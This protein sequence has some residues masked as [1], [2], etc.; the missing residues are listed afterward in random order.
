MDVKQATEN[1]AEKETLLALLLEEAGIELPRVQSITQREKADSYPLSFAQ[2]RLWFLAQLE[3]DSNQYNVPLTLHLD[4]KLSV[5]VLEKSLA[6]ILRRHEALRTC[7][8]VIDD[9]PMQVISAAQALPLP[10]TDL[11]QLVD[12]ASAAERIAQEEAQ[13]RFDLAAGPLFRARLLRLGAEEHVLLLT[14]HHIVSD[15]WSTG[16]LVQ[17]LSA[18]YTAYAQR[19]PSPLAELAIQYADYAVWQRGWLQGA[20]LDEQLQY[21]REQLEGAPAVLELPTDHSRPAVQSFRGARQS[22]RLDHGVSEQLQELSRREGVTLFMSLLAA[23]QVLLARYSG[24]E[25]IVVGSPIAGRTRG[26]TEGLIGFFVNTLVLRGDLSGDPSF[27]E[28]LQRVKEV[29]LGAYG[30]QEVPFEKLVEEL[31]P[32]R[33]LSHNPLFQVMFV[34]QNTPREEL[35]LPGL[36][37]TPV[38]VNDES[39]TKFDLTL[40]ALQQGAGL[41]VDLEYNRDLFEAATVQRML[42]HFETLLAGI[43]AAPQQRLSELPFLTPAEQQRLLVEWNDTSRPLPENKCIHQLFEKQV[44]LT[45]E[46]VAVSDEKKQLSYA[47]LNA[48]A[49][50]LAHYLGEQGVRA[51]VLVGICMERS[52]ELVVSLLAVLKAGGAYV[53]LD[54]TYPEQRLSYMLQ[55]AGVRVLLSERKWRERVAVR[56]GVQVLCREDWSAELASR[57]AANPAV[58]LSATNLAYVIYTSGST[59]K[60]KGVAIE[61]HSTTTF[62]SWAKE[63]FS[64]AE[65]AGVLFSTSICFDLSVFEMFTPLSC[66]GKVIVAGNAL[67]LPS[68]AEAPEVTLIN[69]VPSA[70]AELLR[71]GGIPDSVRTVNLAGEPLQ[72]TLV[73]QIYESSCVERV[74]NLYGP[75]EDTTYSTYTLVKRGLEGAPTIGRPIANTEVYIL[76]KELRPVPVGVSGELY[77]AGEGL[78][79][80]YLHRPELTAERFVPHPYSTRPGARAYR[81]GDAARYLANGEIEY[82]G[83]LDHQVKLRGYRIELGEVESALNAQAGVSE[84][85]V[86]VREDE[87]GEKRLVGYVVAEAGA[88]VSSSE[89][90]RGL[91]ERLPE[92][93]VP[94]ALVLLERL[95]LTA[96]GKV[97]RRELPAPDGRRP[98]LAAAYV[99]PRTVVEEVLVEIWREVL[100]VEQVGIHDNFFELGGHSLLATQVV[101]RVRQVLQREMGLRSLFERPTVAGL[102]EQLEEKSEGSSAPPPVLAVGREQSLPLSFAQQRLWLI[103]QLEQGTAAYNIPAALR[104]R[105]QLQVPVLEA[106][107]TEVVRRHEALRT[108]FPLIDGEPVQL[109]SAA[110]ALPLPLTD[111]SQQAEAANLVETIAQE[112]AQQRFD[113]A[114]GPLFRARL[115]RLGAEEHVL[116]LTMHHIV[117]DGWSIGVLV[118]ELSALYTAYAQRQSS[119]LAELAIQYAD[120]AVWQR[121]WL[122]GAVLDEQ[123]QYWREQLEG[124]PAVLE[125]PTDHSR[126]AVQ[127]FRGARHSLRLDHGVSDQLKELSRREGVTLFM[128]LLAA[129]QVLLARYSGQEEIVVGS[130][131]AGRTRSETEGLIGFFVNTLVLRGD[132][133]GDPSFAELLQ[134][135]KE[136]CLGAYGHQ[137]VPFEKLVEELQ[138]ERS[139]SHNPL[140]QVMFVLQNTPREELRLPDLELTPVAVNNESTKFD[141]TLIASERGAELQVDLEYNRDLFEAATV[142]RMLEQFE[143]VLESVALNPLERLSAIRMLGAE[144]QRQLI[145]E[146]NDTE[147]VCGAAVSVHEAF[148]AQ[149]ARSPEA[150]AVVWGTERITYAELNERANQLG[151]YLQRAGVGPEVRVG[152]WLERSIEMVVGVLGV[153]K[154][155]GAYV[156][157]DPQHPAERV[158]FMAR[159]A[160]LKVVLQGES[161]RR[162]PPEIKAK[163]ISLAAERET[164]ARERVTNV[165][166]KAAPENLAYVIYTSGSMGQPKGVLI[167]HRSALNLSGALQQR[168]YQ[169]HEERPMRVSMNAPLTFDS[170][171]KQWLT[172]LFGCTLYPVPEAVR[173]D[174]EALLAFVAAHELQVLDCTPSQL[175]TLIEEWAKP[176]HYCPAVLLVGGE[177]IERGLWRQLRELER[178]D[179][180]NLY[181]PTECT[182][183]A[184]ISR[185]RTSGEKPNIGRP[186]ANTQVYLL[187]RQGTLVP[188]GAVGE[189]HIGGVGVGRGYLERAD[190][191]AARFIPNPFREAVGERLYRTG[192][193]ARYGANG[194]L[195]FLGRVDQQVKVRGFRIELGEVEAELNRHPAIRDTVVSVRANAAGLTRLVAY[196]ILLAG[197]GVRRSELR[198]HLKKRL[199]DYMIPSTFMFLDA[200]PLTRNGKVDREALPL[201]AEGDL[202]SVFVAPRTP[203]EKVLVGVWEEVLKVDRVGVHDSFFELGGHSLLATQVISRLRQILQVELSLRSLFEMPRVADLAEHL[204]REEAIPGQIS[205]TAALH[206]KIS[207]M[208]AAEVQALLQ[209]KKRLEANSSWM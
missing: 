66:G 106:A 194:C 78:A 141:L 84:A 167:E 57:S 32:E 151:H 148:E 143:R 197:Q 181:G 67:D 60:P 85:V 135:V 15:G 102:A 126:P 160:G 39:T 185:T 82:Q 119:P 80:G 122:Q 150:T 189:L 63:V 54:P 174:S 173:G 86:V 131:I 163:V 204:I 52:V 1:N 90:R 136:V 101:S 51:D 83:R 120:Y 33:S 133:S 123:L 178:V 47:E 16:V 44:R 196:V 166:S 81:T 70:M 22:L 177:A 71:I 207:K 73:Q 206:L 34:L 113:L 3:L 179:S 45:P 46:A 175:T 202:E 118:K 130:P 53:P 7:F 162:L 95:P 140:F 29:C 61:H 36:E 107:L 149:V 129:W 97:N 124:A 198:A 43:V 18:L 125:L 183:D 28:L 68:L 112:E 147:V 138:P 161:E 98:E 153:L 111:L 116:L 27:A 41:Q 49:N 154:A 19:Q 10:L 50:Q 26:E 25:E 171:V 79:R 9:E 58:E 192:D 89:L 200:L 96:N 114:A 12:G 157:L 99:G 134:R 155:G 2:Q 17:E 94:A 109:I 93:M 24:Q 72:N 14:M 4:G 42:G 40:V 152:L 132:L 203:L 186:V 168:V 38:V 30:H 145:D 199:P 205:T 159:D 74:L 87:P 144:E 156:P 13:Q 35:R 76:S 142:Q 172:L 187:D 209:S 127:S 121:E 65:L 31:Q 191:T 48:R 190:L 180:Y 104:L 5:N 108:C 182:V 20:V 176:E 59:G 115:L 128:S 188:Q 100:R 56:E 195:E 117:S 165:E 21:W 164:I 23:W 170:S 110:Q 146:Y 105:G 91:Q 193:L 103:E 137:E 8:P 62:L 92:Y 75:S 55:D 6:E 77:V 69:T 201:P 158:A 208:S 37:L 64:A 139:L 169:G 11:S 88:P 184:T